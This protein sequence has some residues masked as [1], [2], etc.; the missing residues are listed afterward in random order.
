MSIEPVTPSRWHQYARRNALQSLVLI[1]F[2]GGFLALLGWQL[3]GAS[4]LVIL[5]LMG[6]TAVLFNPALSPGWVMRL[7]G[8]TELRRGQLPALDQTLAWLSERAGLQQTPVLYLIPSRVMNAFSVGVPG[9]SAIA[10]SDAM[11]R[12]LTLRELAGVLAHEVSHIRNNDL[13]VMGLA[14]LFSRLTSLLAFVGQCLLILNLPLLLFGLVTI[15]WWLIL[16]LI[17]APLVSALAQLALSRT[18]E[19]AADLNAARLTGDPEGLAQALAAIEREQGGWLEHVL[20]PGRRVPEPSLLRTHPQTA[21][22]VE[23]LL[24]LKPELAEQ[25]PLPLHELLHRVDHAQAT[26]RPRRRFWGTWW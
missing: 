25:S 11:L 1:L 19:Y 4:G 16:L 6:G 18:R 12:R 2:M 3:W 15:D 13:W 24:A 20:M 5:L 26:Q 17:I 23:R 22:R 10:L 7:Y 21:A 9:R 8:A 14:D